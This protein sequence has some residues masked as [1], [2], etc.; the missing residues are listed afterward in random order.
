MLSR[1]ALVDGSA[2]LRFKTSRRPLA[3]ATSAGGMFALVAVALCVELLRG[4][5]AR[6]LEGRPFDPANARAL[7][8]LGALAAGIG[9]GVPAAE[10][11][12][13]RWVLGIVQVQGIAL[14]PALRG[15]L[16]PF[17]VALLLEGLAAVF[18]H[19]AELEA[20]RS[21]TI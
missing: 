9:I 2:Q 7:H 13:A 1:P 11:L 17:L 4:V 12:M 10:F 3:V 20:E 15:S 21:L 19:G 8:R 16:T 6:V 14:A 18:R 5:I